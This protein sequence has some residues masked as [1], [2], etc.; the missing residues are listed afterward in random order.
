MKPIS[1]EAWV[2]AWVVAIIRRILVSC[3]NH[4]PPRARAAV[5]IEWPERSWLFSEKRRRKKIFILT[6]TFIHFITKFLWWFKLFSLNPILD[7]RKFFVRSFVRPSS[8]I[9][10]VLHP[11]DSETNCTG[12]L[13][14]NGVLLILENSKDSLF[15][16]KNNFK[17]NL[18][19]FSQDWAALESSG[20]T[21]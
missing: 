19:F 20:Q 5:A 4:T 10:L 17:N 7:T 2:I 18:D 11:L 13:W 1:N 14:L 6:K 3:E 8:S 15:C 9:T 16:G 21:V 12:E